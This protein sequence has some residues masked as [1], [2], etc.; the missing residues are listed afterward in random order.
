MMIEKNVV[1]SML[2]SY[3]VGLKKEIH[4]IEA[5]LNRMRNDCT[6]MEIQAIFNQSK[7]YAVLMGKMETLSQVLMDIVDMRCNAALDG[8]N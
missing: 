1:K 7:E 3:E 5:N 6:S 4:A 8:G 2:A